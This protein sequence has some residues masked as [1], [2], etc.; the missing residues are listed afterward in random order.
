MDNIISIVV[1]R[2]E[3]EEYLE[4]KNNIMNMS[5]YHDK[6]IIHLKYEI[7]LCFSIFYKNDRFWADL[8]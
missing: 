4:R 3:I 5:V 2:M 6:H 8:L 7:P 1:S